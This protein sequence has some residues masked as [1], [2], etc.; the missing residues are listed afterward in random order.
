MSAEE[1]KEYSHRRPGDRAPLGIST[2]SWRWRCSER[3]RPRRPPT[4]PAFTTSVGSARPHQAFFD[5][6]PVTIRYRFSARRPVDVAI[7]IVRLADERVVRR[8]VDRHV[9]AAADAS[10][11]LGGLTRAG[12]A[13]PDGHYAILV[14]R[15][16]HRLRRVGGFVL[17]GHVF[18]VRG[19]HGSRGAIGQFGA[20]RAAGGPRRVRRD[21]RLRTPLVAARG[22]RVLRASSTPS[23]TAGSS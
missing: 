9:G 21:G 17:H 5:G 4:T 10:P 11:A 7:R 22:G 18:P 15:R 6:G 20:P 1:A 2:H 13:A 14:G 16:G 8:L 19:P 23:S 12:G 3:R